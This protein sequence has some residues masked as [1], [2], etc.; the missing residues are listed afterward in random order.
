M[1]GAERRAASGV[2]VVPVAAGVRQRGA[3]PGGAPQVHREAA[4]WGGAGGKHRQSANT[5]PQALLIVRRGG[6]GEGEIDGGFDQINLT[7]FQSE[8]D[9]Y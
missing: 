4:A 6:C 1:G 3:R 7:F 5:C 9:G 2:R 8:F